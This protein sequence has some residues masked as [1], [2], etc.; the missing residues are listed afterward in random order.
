VRPAALT[1]AK[2]IK[3]KFTTLPWLTF[4]MGGLEIVEAERVWLEVNDGSL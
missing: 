2:E 3:I 4:V 1:R